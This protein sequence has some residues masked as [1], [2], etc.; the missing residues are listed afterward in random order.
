MMKEKLKKAINALH[1]YKLLDTKRFYVE[2][3]LS[4]RP[5]EDTNTGRRPVVHIDF[6][7]DAEGFSSMVLI[8]PVFIFL[9]F[10][11]KEVTNG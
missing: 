5:M 4:A 2:V 8:Y 1:T 6:F 3:G 9:Y 7:K 11:P 10:K